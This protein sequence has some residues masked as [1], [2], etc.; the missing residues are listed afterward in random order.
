M[1]KYIVR[2]SYD[3]GLLIE[4]K[5]TAINLLES[6]PVRSE[7]YPDKEWA[8]DDRELSLLVIDD[9]KIKEKESA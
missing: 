9:S 4:N 5:E 1:K 8:L 6:T 3:S 7:G 2:T